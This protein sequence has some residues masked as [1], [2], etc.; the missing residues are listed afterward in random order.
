[1]GNWTAT[2][3]APLANGSYTITATQADGSFA[4]QSFTEAAA[5]PAVS[6]L[7]P[8]NGQYTSNA[9]PMFAGSS[10]TPG[11]VTVSISGP[12]NTSTSATV[13]G[14]D[15]WSA[16]SPTLA[17][18][19]YTAT[20]SET[21]NANTGHSA[22]ISFTVVAPPAVTISA[23]ANG[24]TSGTTS[25][26]FAGGRG[27]A[28]GDNGAVDLAIYAGTSAA[29]SPVVSMATNVSGASWSATATGLANGTYTAIAQQGDAAGTTGT[30]SPVTFTIAAP[31]PPPPPPTT[32]TTAA[33]PVTSSTSAPA[34]PA[35]PAQPPSASI[36]VAPAGPIVV[37][38]TVTL[39]SSSSAGAGSSIAALAWDLSGTGKFAPGSGAYATVRFTTPG[40]HLV[41]L[42]VTDADGLSST[43]QATIK[44]GKANVPL[45]TPFPIV[46]IDG[47]FTS[48]GARIALLTVRAPV[49]ARVAVV[50]VG[51][52]CPVRSQ[53]KIAT[54]AKR[55]RATTVLVELRRFERPLPAGVVLQI[56]VT[57][58]NEVGKFTSFAIRRGQ[59]PKRADL[60]VIPGHPAPAAC[61]A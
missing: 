8:P 11:T 52:A 5:V 58:A 50:C 22:A 32:T 54:A 37:G 16:T 47:G 19:S 39:A 25:E 12:T 36:V 61:P 48:R 35:P 2:P 28:P 30:S 23:P 43:A 40:S 10:N 4:T 34:T 26:H 51:K 29:G 57:A 9:T 7:S 27:T 59:V 60:C 14:D 53:V 49:G 41:R 42:R 56:S 6:I 44:V 1:L 13:Q 17:P 21:S 24:S 3:T 55:H 33:A 38:E 31:P 45:M 18:G 46:R 20:A 15:S